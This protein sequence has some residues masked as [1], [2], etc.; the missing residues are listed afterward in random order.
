[1]FLQAVVVPL[2]GTD[3]CPGSGLCLCV[4][5]CGEIVHVY[6]CVFPL[7]SF[8][9]AKLQAS[10]FLVKCPIAIASWVFVLGIL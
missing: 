4:S 5:L 10:S 7:Y 2:Y 3:L 6:L 9:T 1:M 8:Y